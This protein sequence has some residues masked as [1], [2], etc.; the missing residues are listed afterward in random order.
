MF[1][2]RTGYKSIPEPMWAYFYV[3]YMRHQATI[4]YAHDLV[5]DLNLDCQSDFGKR[6][7]NVIREHYI[8]YDKRI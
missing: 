4:G 5:E 7:N 6:M 8:Y 2:R 3:A 1:L